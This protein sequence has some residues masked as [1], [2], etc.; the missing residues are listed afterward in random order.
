VDHAVQ[1]RPLL[2]GRE[3]GERAFERA[4]DGGVRRGFVGCPLHGGEIPDAAAPLE[5]SAHE[6]HRPIDDAPRHVASERR[7]QELSGG[8]GTVLDGEARGEGK[9]QHHHGPKRTSFSRSAGSRY[10]RKKDSPAIL[11]ISALSECKRV[12][13]RYDT[14]VRRLLRSQC[15][16]PG[17]HSRGADARRAGGRPG[18]ATFASAAIAILPRRPP[19]GATEQIAER[20]GSAIGG[21]LNAT[22]GNAPEL[23][24]AVVALRAGELE[25][26]KGSIIGAILG[27]LLFVLGLSFLLGGL[28]Q[29][30][31]VYNPAGARIQSS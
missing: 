11:L 29:H 28:R 13:R 14:R 5:E 12:G 25:L 8:V 19:R 7:D 10:L 24:I 17:L 9:G 30:E 16:A 27:N 20:A 22:F 23:I 15:A 4:G 31:Q 2:L 3:R 26:V 1:P 6:E 18:R 21:L